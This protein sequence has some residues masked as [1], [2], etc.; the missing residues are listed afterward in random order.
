MK[1][2]KGTGTSITE[3]GE[4]VNLVNEHMV[5]IAETSKEQSS[6]IAD[7]NHVIRQLDEMTQ[8]N[9]ALAEEANAAT[10]TL[11][12][13]AGELS[14]LIAT[15]ELNNNDATGMEYQYAEAS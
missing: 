7:V 6:D 1:L 5:S 12:D 8:Q 9:A 14:K 3:I 2:V 4:K 13:L 15:F 11:A 10:E